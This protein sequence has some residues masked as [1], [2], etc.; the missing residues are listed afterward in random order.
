MVI[1]D[2]HC[3]PSQR[4]GDFLLP[5]NLLRGSGDAETCH[6]EVELFAKENGNGIRMHGLRESWPHKAFNIGRTRV[7][8]SGDNLRAFWVLPSVRKVNIMLWAF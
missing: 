5:F 7:F 1:A 8:R 3:A 6:G 2:S 4:Y